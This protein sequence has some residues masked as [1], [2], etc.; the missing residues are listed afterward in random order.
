MSKYIG[1]R[2]GQKCC[3][4]SPLF[5][6][7]YSQCPMEL[8]TPAALLLSGKLK[9]ILLMLSKW[10]KTFL[11][12]QGFHPK[13]IGVN[14]ISTVWPPNKPEQ[15]NAVTGN[16]IKFQFSPRF[17]QTIQMLRNALLTTFCENKL[18]RSISTKMVNKHY[19]LFTTITLMHSCNM[20]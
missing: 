16:I 18:L 6:T 9:G 7:C 12:V 19:P 8:L 20:C 13:T 1:T 3:E 4:T 5:Q 2:A 14:V 10:I 17:K 11:I 15:A